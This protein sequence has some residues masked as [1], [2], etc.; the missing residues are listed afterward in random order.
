[1]VGPTE[2]VRGSELGSAGLLNTSLCDLL[3]IKYPIMQAGMGNLARA[4]LA[5][6]VSEAG[7][8]GV[9]GS[10]RS[11]IDDFRNEVRLVKRLTDKPFGVDILFAEV[12]G[13]DQD[14][15]EYTQEVQS[16]I[17][18]ALEERVPV[19]VSGLGSPGGVI[20]EAHGLGMTVMSI[21]GNTKHAK[22]LVSEGVDGIIASGHEG[23]GH[24]G[25]I[26]TAVLIPQVVD[27]VDVPVVAGGGLVDGRGLVAALSFGAVGV[28]MGTRYVATEEAYT[29]DNYKDKIVEIDEEGTII[30]RASSGKPVRMIRNKFTEYWEAHEA[31][32]EPFPSQFLK[33]GQPAA[34]KGR[35]DG[36]VEDGSLP[37]G[38]GAGGI[39]GVK[40]A[41]E[42]TLDIVE[43]AQAALRRLC[44]VAR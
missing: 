3:G 41:G 10:A 26:G 36:D 29:H 5:A 27:A 31:E 1:M 16:Q 4:R 23:G 18:I 28:W 43:E 13:T 14:S 22:R 37:C 2:N 21:V 24:V 6:A 9:L 20:Q 40:G 34:I 15:T 33:V 8:L 38:Q 44:N 42:V 11:T 35:I 25:R 12:R 30:S 19:L 32:I 7:G 39:R 17:Q